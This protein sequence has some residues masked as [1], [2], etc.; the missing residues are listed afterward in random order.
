MFKKNTQQKSLDINQQEISTIIGEGYVFTGELQG[1]SVIR[2]E[3]K[4]IGNVNVEGGVVLGE[5]GIIDGDIFTKSA[6]IFGTVN[7]NVKSGQLEIKRSGIV[8]GDISTDTLE[9]E[10]G[11]QF[12]GKLNMQRPQQQVLAEAS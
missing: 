7:G 4:I 8:S 9:I 11:A 2:I 5:K 10:L 1:S 6:I 3:G 12:N